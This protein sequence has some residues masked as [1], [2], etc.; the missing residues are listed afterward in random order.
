MPI[1]TQYRWTGLQINNGNKQCK[2]GTKNFRDE[3]QDFRMSATGKAL[4]MN[5]QIKNFKINRKEK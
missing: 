4:D 1:G 2:I 3:C 5:K